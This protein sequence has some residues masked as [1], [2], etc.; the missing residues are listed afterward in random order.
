MSTIIVQHNT[1]QYNI[2][3]YEKYLAYRLEGG[4]KEGKFLEH[5]SHRKYRGWL[6]Q[7]HGMYWN[8]QM[9]CAV[10]Y[11]TPSLTHSFRHSSLIPCIR[12]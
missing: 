6:S 4:I 3:R 2:H 7:D 1:I 5:M 12:V 10:G 11:N 8:Q 9:P